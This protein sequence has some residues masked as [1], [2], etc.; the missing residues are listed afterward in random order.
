ME[1]YQIWAIVCILFLFAEIMTPSLFF[2]NLSLGC[3]CAGIFGYYKFS[4][5]VQIWVFVIVSAL[6]LIILRP[7]LLKNKKDNAENVNS[8]I[9]GKYIN[10]EAIVV[11]DITEK[12]GKIKVFDEIWS[13]KS[14][15][16]ENILKDTKVKIIKNES[17][18]MIVEKI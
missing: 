12:G 3:A 1:L 13:A 2:L 11:E 16:G 5:P 9:E 14:S 7:L 8:V 15:N 6:C 10:L 4:Y 17:L 18:T